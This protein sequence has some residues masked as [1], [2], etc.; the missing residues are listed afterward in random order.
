M[1][2][3]YISQIRVKI[4]N[5]SF[6]RPAYIPVCTDEVIQEFFNTTV[7]DEDKNIR[8]SI[9]E[10]SKRHP[11]LLSK[12]HEVN[13]VSSSTS[14]M[15]DEDLMATVVKRENNNIFDLS[16]AAENIKND[17]EQSQIEEKEKAAAESEKENE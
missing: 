4:A 6:F 15:T 9:L 11:D 2:N 16:R 8:K 1:K 13:T 12:L 3:V 7:L 14:D 10:L 17:L 5:E